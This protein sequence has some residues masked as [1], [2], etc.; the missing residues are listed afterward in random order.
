[1]EKGQRLKAVIVNAESISSVDSSALHM[2]HDLTKDLRHQGV[3]LYFSSVI[4]PV[5]DAMARAHL[6]EEIGEDHFQMSIE[7]AVA[8]IDG[9]S[10]AENSTEP[11]SSY[12]LQTND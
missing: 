6:V 5:R 2:L 8:V 12:T 7:D 9:K 10:G 1:M 4:G 3:E 11:L